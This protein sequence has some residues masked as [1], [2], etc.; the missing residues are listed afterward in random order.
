MDGGP[1]GERGERERADLPERDCALGTDRG[2]QRQGDERH[3][4]QADAPHEEPLSAR[5]G[6]TRAWGVAHARRQT[7]RWGSR[8][9]QEERSRI[10]S[11]FQV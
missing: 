11:V 1:E 4:P 9:D 10:S 7:L 8:R 5:G 2:G 6:A 3:Q